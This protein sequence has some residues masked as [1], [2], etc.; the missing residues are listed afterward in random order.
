[1]STI[2]PANPSCDRADRKEISAI[3]PLHR[4]LPLAL[5]TLSCVAAAAQ[6]ERPREEV[7]PSEHPDEP[8]KEERQ[9]HEAEATHF[10]IDTRNLTPSERLRMRWWLEW[11]VQG[12]H[13]P[14]PV[15][16]AR[17]LN[18][19]RT[20]H[21]NNTSDY[22][23]YDVSPT[24]TSSSQPL[25]SDQLH[26]IYNSGSAIVNSGDV[27]RGSNWAELTGNKGAVTVIHQ[28]ESL[29]RDWNQISQ[30]TALADRP[31]PPARTVIFNALPQ[32]TAPRASEDELRRMNIVGKT[33]SWKAL[34]DQ[35][36]NSSA[37]IQSHV[38]TKQALL[39]E[40]ATGDSDVIVVYAHFDG[41]RLH[42]PGGSAANHANLA[43]Y[44]IGVDELAK[45]NRTGSP[46]KNRVIVLAACS[47]AAHASNADSLVQVLLKQGIA[48]SVLATDK[49]YDA[50]N[51]PDL[52][53]RLKSQQPLRQAG[54]QLRQYVE[55]RPIS[56]LQLQ[57]IPL[58][59]IHPVQESETNS[60]E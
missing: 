7:R 47:T 57:P 51:I 33:E 60:G 28:Q 5:L 20:R 39:T 44:T 52:M 12:E 56:P 29:N 45:I 18:W 50:R 35:I 27:P 4:L 10:E 46:A 22:A 49:P 25:T 17:H 1:M 58:Q 9:L 30:A 34:N 54:G 38:A 2:Q 14:P 26:S 19:V 53:Q 37:G 6:F 48:G 24:L 59:S 40:L 32:E 23:A 43:D 42:L 36:R 8:S 16:P 31:L 55:L 15:A 21:A 13:G 3:R 41:L 11:K